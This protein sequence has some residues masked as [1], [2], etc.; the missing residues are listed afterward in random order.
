[1][2]NKLKIKDL[3]TTGIFFVIYFVVMFAVGLIGLVPILF[4]IYPTILGIVTGTIILLYMA[5]VP[6]PWALF[7]LGMLS[8][9]VMFA[10]GHTFIVPLVSAIF[11]GI[12]E[13]FFR[14]GGFKSFKYNAIAFA[15]FNCWIS[16][17]LMQMLLAKEQYQAI[18]VKSGMDP[19][20]FEKLEALISVPSLALVIVGAFIG[21]LIGAYV[22]KAMLKKHFNKAGIV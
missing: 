21:G 7:I 13:F 4:L 8:P 22:G 19:S 2:S 1:M 17:S 10:M 9:L 16:G 11:F 14:K 6:K 15:F 3:V 18:H 20:Y 12:A 5:K